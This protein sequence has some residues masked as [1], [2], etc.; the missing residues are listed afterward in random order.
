MTGADLVN[1]YQYL[2]GTEIVSVL[3]VSANT[4]DSSV[5]A[6]NGTRIVLEASG[7][8]APS[9]PVKMEW[10]LYAATMSFVPAPGDKI[11][12][13]ESTI[14]TIHNVQTVQILTADYKYNC[15]T[16]SNG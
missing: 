14:W 11:T 6:M 1:D 8:P 7:S 9:D 10:T 15:T 13:S 3:D 12:D 2:D 5:T 16:T 4:T